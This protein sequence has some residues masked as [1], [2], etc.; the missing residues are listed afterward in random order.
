MRVPCSVRILV[1]ACM[2]VRMCVYKQPPKQH[3]PARCRLFEK[4]QIFLQK[5]LYIFFTSNRRNNIPPQGADYL[6]KQTNK[7]FYENI[8]IYF[9]QATT[10]TTFPRKVQTIWRGLHARW[11]HGPPLLLHA[12]TLDVGRHVA[13]LHSGRQISAASTCELLLLAT[14]TSSADRHVSCTT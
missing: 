11:A 1:S 3:S 9:V 13:L 2:C 4:K 8:C 6:K 7:Y 14:S 10:E 5:Y 12:A